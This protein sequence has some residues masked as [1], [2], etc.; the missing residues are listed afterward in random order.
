MAVIGDI[1]PFHLNQRLRRGDRLQLLDVREPEEVAIAPFPGA[2][3]I[4]MGDVASQRGALDPAAEWV[5]ICHHGIRSAHVA[6]YLARMGFERVVN[7]VGG[8]DRWSLTVDPSVP[9][10]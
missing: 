5:I 7:L 10:Y 2:L 4:P 9:R 1:E 8:I 6:L 3:H